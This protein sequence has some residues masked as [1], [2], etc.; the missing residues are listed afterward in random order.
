[1]L[2]LAVSIDAAAVLNGTSR[3]EQ[4]RPNGYAL[5]VDYLR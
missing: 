3:E 1:M 2:L 5:E 4:A